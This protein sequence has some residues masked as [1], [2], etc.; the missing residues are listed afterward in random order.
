MS[1][2]FPCEGCSRPLSAPD[3]KAGKL[4]ICPECGARLRVPGGNAPARP[5]VTFESLPDAEPRT[6]PNVFR[7]ATLGESESVRSRWTDAENQDDSS[8]HADDHA[9]DNLSPPP[10]TPRPSAGKSRRAQPARSTRAT[11]S[12]NVNRDV[13]DL[14]L[15]DDDLDG[16]GFQ[17]P[18]CQSRE[19]PNVRQEISVGGWIVFAALLFFCFPLC[20][21]GLF[22]REDRHFCA[23]CG[24]RLDTH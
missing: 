17:C 9:G 22:I 11:R 2:H 21:I 19:R 3:D 16:P 18:Y 20:F 13:V 4:A 14:E 1:I 15:L 7:P 12:T 6:P 24:I 10:P 8:D 23:D 5:Q